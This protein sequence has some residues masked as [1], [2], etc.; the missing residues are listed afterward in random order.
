MAPLRG[1]VVSI[2]PEPES[3]LNE[4]ETVALLARCAIANG[5]VGVRIE[6]T[7]RIA[8]VRAATRAPII[9]LVKRAYPG[10]APYITATLLEVR[11]AI[12]AG[13][14]MIAVDATPRT[15]PDGSSLSD[16][17]ATIHARGRLAMADCADEDDLR[18]AAALGF[19]L[20]G[21]TL[22]GY[23]DATRG[24]PLPALDLVAAVAS[25]LPG[26]VL[27]GGVREPA[28]VRAAFAVGADVVVVGTA[29]TNLDAAIRAF[30]AG[31]RDSDAAEG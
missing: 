20:V 1:L 12:D 13:A 7:I 8:A 5:A 26:V 30:A 31:V 25:D 27:E 17:L 10:F 14:D 21:T 23:T 15:R 9:G 22:A 11:E 3:V 28:Q 24:R 29:L 16:A 19:D 4:P 18:A 2:Q 6:G